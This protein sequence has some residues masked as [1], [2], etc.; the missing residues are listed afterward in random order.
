M[1]NAL[2]VAQMMAK[3]IHAGDWGKFGTSLVIGITEHTHQMSSTDPHHLQRISMMRFSSGKSNR[4]QLSLQRK[5]ANSSFL[6]FL[7]ARL[8]RLASGYAPQTDF[9]PFSWRDGGYINNTGRD[10]EMK[11]TQQASLA[12]TDRVT[13]CIFSHLSSK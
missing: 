6:L 4:A 7:S 10:R 2:A 11:I 3:V 8:C 9:K 1:L 5:E 12:E 13:G